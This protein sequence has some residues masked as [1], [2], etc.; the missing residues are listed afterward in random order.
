MNKKDVSEIRRRLKKDSCTFTRIC[1]CYVDGERNRVVKLSE[2]FLNLEDEEFYKYLEIAR[3]VLSGTLG[4]NLLELEFPLEA[5]ALGGSQHFLTALRGSALQ[6]EDLLERFYDLIID[7]YD[8]AGNYLILIF[9]DAYDVI[10]KTSDNSKL[11]ESEEVYEYLLCAICPVSLSK[12]ALGYRADENRI[13]A[14][15]RDWVVDAPES[16]FVFPA[17]TDRSSDLHA[18]MTYHK[19]VKA[20][21]TELMEEILGC[22]ARRTATEQK[23]A[24]ASIVK[25]A[26]G[27][28]ENSS[29]EV[30][31][32]IQQELSDLSKENQ[33]EDPDLPEEPI[34]LTADTI[35]ELMAESDVPEQ[36][37]A[38]IEEA[39]R[40]EFEDELPILEHLIDGKAAE[41][42]GRMKRQKELVQK[43]A[44]LEQQLGDIKTYD[45][46]LRV[47]PEKEPLIQSQIING[48]KCIVIPMEENEHATINGINRFL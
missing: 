34:R 22:T 3:K 9:H 25:N 7:N 26:F 32:E 41:E 16:G 30:F 13:G 6:N 42:G 40:Q 15:I 43:V 20:P 12:P 5:E 18:V 14:R 48:K 27:S 31:C 19:N 24:F 23:L 36:A 29:Q 47:K 10:T 39:Y 28:D 35:G 33:S 45:V 21:H 8:Y 37:A 2:T 46:I 17:F 4:N 38:V 1:G 11:D 44:D